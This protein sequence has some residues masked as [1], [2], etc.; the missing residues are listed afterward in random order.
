[1]NVSLK[2]GL[3]MTDMEEKPDMEVGMRENL[4]VI[5]IVL[6]GFIL[7][8]ITIMVMVLGISFDLVCSII[9][10]DTS[11]SGNA[12]QQIMA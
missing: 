6:T 1:M 10:L 5:I 3:G 4:D 9:I 2:F 8:I 7:I 12:T 11:D